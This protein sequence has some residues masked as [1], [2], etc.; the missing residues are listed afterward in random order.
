MGQSRASAAASTSSKGQTG[1]RGNSSGRR[2]RPNSSPRTAL[3]T[4]A[5]LPFPRQ[6]KPFEALRK[7]EWLCFPSATQQ[8]WQQHVYMLLI[9][10]FRLYLDDEMTFA[11]VAEIGSIYHNNNADSAAAFKLCFLPLSQQEQLLPT[12]MTQKSCAFHANKCVEF[13]MKNKKSKAW[14]GL[15]TRVTEEDIVK[16]YGDES[17]V[18][19]MRVFASQVYGDDPSGTV[20]GWETRV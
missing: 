14:G 13:G 16:W 20:K 4:A 2:S 11:S 8:H 17:M 19:Q 15:K 3:S 9:D 7:K 6:T 5:L 10:A 18:L 1:G 12:W